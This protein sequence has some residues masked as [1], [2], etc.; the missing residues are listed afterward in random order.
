MNQLIYSGIFSFLFLGTSIDFKG[1]WD[2][3]WLW[4]QSCDFSP[5]WQQGS[6]EATTGC[7][8]GGGYNSVGSSSDVDDGLQWHQC[9]RWQRLCWLSESGGP[10][11]QHLERGWDNGLCWLASFLMLR[12]LISITSQKGKFGQCGGTLDEMRG[13]ARTAIKQLGGWIEEAPRRGKMW[14]D[15]NKIDA[16]CLLKWTS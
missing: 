7:G 8:M 5:I 12:R 15:S 11:H 14:E 1:Q 3:S 2:S 9:R 10:L 6:G 16:Y 13:M 4:R